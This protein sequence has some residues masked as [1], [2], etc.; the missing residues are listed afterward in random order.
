MSAIDRATMGFEAAIYG[1][2]SNASDLSRHSQEGYIVSQQVREYAFRGQRRAPLPR[3]LDMLA[4]DVL[5]T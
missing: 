5:D 2:S 1:R 4:Q 3:G